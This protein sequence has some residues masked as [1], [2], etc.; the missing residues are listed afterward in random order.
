MDPANIRNRPEVGGGALMDIGCYA[1]LFARFAFR[2]EPRRALGLV[3]RDAGMGTD[4]HASV[5]LDFPDGQATLYCSTQLARAQR[6]RILGTGGAIDVEV[7][8]NA[9]DDRP[10]RIVV[11]DGRDVLGS[12]AETIE[13]PAF[14]QY[15]LQGDAISRAILGEATLPMTLEDSVANMRVLDAVFASERSGGWAVV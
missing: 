6:V 10:T 15:T 3:R 4:S 14:N 12:G 1:V 11:D 9:P 13:F 5:I 2:T 8:V 7:P